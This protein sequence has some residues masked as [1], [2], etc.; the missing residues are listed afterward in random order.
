MKRRDRHDILALI[1]SPL[2][3]LAPMAIISFV[4]LESVDRDWIGLLL[5]LLLGLAVYLNMSRIL[6]PSRPRRT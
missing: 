6:S 2:L 1:A 5:L 3:I 4:D